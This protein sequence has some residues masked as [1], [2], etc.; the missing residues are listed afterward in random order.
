M[1]VCSGETE[2]I[3]WRQFSK[4]P[5]YFDTA[6]V[7]RSYTSKRHLGSAPEH[8]RGA[9]A[10]YQAYCFLVP[11]VFRVARALSLESETTAVRVLSYCSSGS[12]E[13][14]LSSKKDERAIY[15][16][17]EYKSLRMAHLSRSYC[18]STKSWRSAVLRP[19][20]RR[21]RAHGHARAAS[22]EQSSSLKSLATQRE[23]ITHGWKNWKISHDCLY[24]LVWNSKILDPRK[25]PGSSSPGNM[26]LQT[27]REPAL[28]PGNRVEK[29]HE[30]PSG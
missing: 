22:E 15:N 17:I 20:S 21:P 3:G 28:R 18:N 24:V 19:R 12:T 26:K 9:L 13:K 2:N 7:P 11:V 10:V 6:A 27:D 29:A 1:D 30:R 16:Q 4:E 25:R 14:R 23:R 8:T 5:P